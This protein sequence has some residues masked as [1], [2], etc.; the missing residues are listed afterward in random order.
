[1]E[2]KKM[3]ELTNKPPTEDGFYWVMHRGELKMAKVKTRQCYVE[4]DNDVT[5][6][7]YIANDGCTGMFIV[8]GGNGEEYPLRSEI[9]EPP[10]G[11]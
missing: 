6:F 11:V 10:K 5:E 7:R 9:I 3:T 8:W 1:V 2:V 4:K